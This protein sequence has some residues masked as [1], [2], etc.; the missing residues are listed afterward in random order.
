MKLI[1]SAASA[2][3]PRAAFWVLALGC[4]SGC[5]AG[6]ADPQSAF[7]ETSDAEVSDGRVRPQNDELDM[8]RE[9]VPAPPSLRDPAEVA[10]GDVEKPDYVNSSGFFTY[11]GRL[12]DRY[13]NDFV[14]R[15]VN[16]AHAWF[17]TNSTPVATLALD[18]IAGFGFNAI[19]IVWEANNAALS[20]ELLRTVVARTVQLQM[21]PM[22]EL[23]DATGSRDPQDLLTLA[24]YFAEPDVKDVLVE[25][26]DYLL[27]NIANEWSGPDDVYFDAYEAAVNLIRGAD[28]PHTL[29]IDANGWGQNDRVV[30]DEGPALLEADPE[31]NLLLSVHMYEA[32]TN[33]DKITSTFERAVE[34]QIPLIVGEFGYQHG[35]PP[36]PIDVEHLMAEASRL[37]IGHIGWS[38]KGNGAKVSY[39]DMASD[40]EGEELTDWGLRLID[41]EFGIGATSQRA[42]LFLL[43]TD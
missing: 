37:G 5:G 11:E 41:G 34:D 33:P 24:E 19:R 12:Y 28:L 32:F 14:I 35:T 30:F 42:S 29:V 6:S 40:W 43:G 31:H 21:V 25:F 2:H 4:Y 27:L 1:S 16:N 3:L 26:E 8:L 10:T 38:W 7:A 22:L 20:P 36:V 9:G 39:L 18:S 15:G 13:G 17:D 23:H